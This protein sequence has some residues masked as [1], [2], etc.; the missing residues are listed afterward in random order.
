MSN[1]KTWVQDVA[2]R[3]VKT[4]AQAAASAVTANT[5]GITHLNLAEVGAIAGGAALACVLQNL[6][7]LKV[8]D[9]TL[10]P[11]NATAG[12][13]LVPDPA[14]APVAPIWPQVAAPGITTT[15]IPGVTVNTAPVDPTVT[16]TA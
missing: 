10:V 1:F 6:S 7:N 13:T 12:A 11:F 14:P 2:L 4:A 8:N 15:T 3:A 9:P 5:A 16:P